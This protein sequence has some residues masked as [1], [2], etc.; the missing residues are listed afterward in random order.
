MRKSTMRF[1]DVNVV[2]PNSRHSL[3]SNLDALAAVRPT[4]RAAKSVGASPASG[5]RPARAVAAT[6]VTSGAKIADCVNKYDARMDN[7]RCVIFQK[8]RERAPHPRQHHVRARYVFVQVVKSGE[9]GQRRYEQEEIR[10]TARRY[11]R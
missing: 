7:R 2:A 3:R 5:A 6:E 11:G 9:H 1:T 8:L 10:V 4:P